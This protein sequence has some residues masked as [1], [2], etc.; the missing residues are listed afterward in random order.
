MDVGGE[1]ISV[2]GTLHRTPDGGDKFASKLDVKL[3]R[4][5][6]ALPVGRPK[7]KKKLKL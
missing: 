7:K 2:L 1:R 4:R 6:R 3:G 5:L